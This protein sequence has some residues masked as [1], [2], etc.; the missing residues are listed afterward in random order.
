MDPRLNI[1]MIESREADLR[2]RAEGARVR[3]SWPDDGLPPRVA[4]GHR[5]RAGSLHPS[6]VLASLLT[7]R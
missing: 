5:P 6:A 4:N 7:W 2:R 3:R 1:A